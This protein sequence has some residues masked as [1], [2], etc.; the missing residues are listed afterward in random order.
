MNETR[1]IPQPEFRPRE[2]SG[3]PERAPRPDPGPYPVVPQP[4]PH[5]PHYRPREAMTSPREALQAPREAL[6]APREGFPLPKAKSLEERH[7]AFRRAADALHDRHYEDNS[8]RL[9]A[10]LRLAE[11]FL[12]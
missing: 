8:L 2:A 9:E 6:N 10:E 3:Q 1:V 7:E 12:K 11:F 4:S 5:D